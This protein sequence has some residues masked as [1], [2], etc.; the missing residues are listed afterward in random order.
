MNGP[1]PSHC[2]GRLLWLILALAPALIQ[3]PAQAALD[4]SGTTI[5][6]SPGSPR[7]GSVATFTVAL[8]NS[9]ASLGDPVQVRIE[10]PLMGYLIDFAGLPEGQVEI[11][12][13]ARTLSAP[14]LLPAGGE[15]LV[16]LRVLVPRDAGGDILGVS[17]RLA[18]YPSQREHWAHGSATVE[19]HIPHDG[20]RVGGLRVSPAG[21]AVVGWIIAYVLL[22][23]L[24]PR[25]AS[26]PGMLGPR[27]AVSAIMIP[28]GFWMIFAAMAWRDCQVLK[29]WPETTATILGRRGIVQPTDGGPEQRSVSGSGGSRRSTVRPEYGLRYTVEGVERFSAGYDTGSSLHIG[30]RTQS[31]EELRDWVVGARIRCWYDPENPADVVI[32]RGFGGAYLLGIITLP[33][34]W[35]GVSLL[36]RKPPKHG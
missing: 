31:G 25:P 35:F 10:W 8:K 27:A 9:G 24:L 17:A 3:S 29:V 4:F 18:H 5:T 1:L 22:W 16:R 20:W 21:L 34:F 11:D 12:H 2:R 28:A 14:V 6:C 23:R 36:R 7:E 33:V 13:E 32:S 15:S 26:D 19:T 30:G